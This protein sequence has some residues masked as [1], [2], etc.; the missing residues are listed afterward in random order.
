MFQSRFSVRVWVRPAFVRNGNFATTHT[1]HTCFFSSC[2]ADSLTFWF[3][4]HGI[5]IR[6]SKILIAGLESQAWEVKHSW[7]YTVGSN[8]KAI[9]MDKTLMVLNASCFQH[10]K[11]SISHENPTAAAQTPP[12]KNTMLKGRVLILVPRTNTKNLMEWYGVLVGVPTEFGIWRFC[13][14]LS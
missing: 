4:R 2:C 5:N 7:K 1:W 13:W 9:E 8:R 14:D 6:P 10:D 3:Y 11:N 12:Q